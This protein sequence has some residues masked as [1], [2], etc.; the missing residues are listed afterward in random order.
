M[1]IFVRHN[2]PST[3]SNRYVQRVQHLSTSSLNIAVWLL[4]VIVLCSR[5]Q[6]YVKTTYVLS[7]RF[8]SRRHAD[9]PGQDAR[10]I[11][12]ARVPIYWPSDYGRS[13]MKVDR[14]NLFPPSAIYCNTSVYSN[15]VLV[16]KET[17]LEFN[18]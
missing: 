11:S 17:F 7:G 3:L 5:N 6:I 8:R 12:T 15:V 18:L 10:P 4:A 13:P 14:R 9:H 1:R 16:L 2:I